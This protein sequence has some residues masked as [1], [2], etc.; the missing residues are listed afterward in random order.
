MDKG[1]RL[2]RD[3]ESLPAYIGHSLRKKPAK[4]PILTPQQRN[5]WI[6]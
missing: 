1:D 5:V 4:R 3:I 6:I 2:L